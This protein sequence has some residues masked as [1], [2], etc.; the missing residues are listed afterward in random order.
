LAIISG[1]E[2]PVRTATETRTSSHFRIILDRLVAAGLYNSSFPKNVI[3][4]VSYIHILERSRIIASYRQSVNGS[5]A[6]RVSSRD[7]IAI[8]F[9]H[10]FTPRTSIDLGLRTY[11]AEAFS[12]TEPDNNNRDADSNR[13]NLWL[14]YTPL[15]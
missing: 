11:Q 10:D 7:E 15:R 1:S 6:G 12:E 2:K 13:V 8:N 3:G 9:R 4:E 14:R 5:G